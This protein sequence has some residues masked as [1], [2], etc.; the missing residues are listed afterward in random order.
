MTGTE[1]PRG[2]PVEFTAALRVAGDRMTVHKLITARDMAQGIGTP[3]CVVC[4][5]PV[6]RLS[7]IPVHHR[8]HRRHGGRGNPGNGITVHDA[9]HAWIHAHGRAATG[10]GWALY[11]SLRW[12]QAAGRAVRCARRGEIVLFD[13]PDQDGAWWRPASDAE[14]AWLDDPLDDPRAAVARG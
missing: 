5:Q 4:G 8:L 10:Q 2:W 7:D 14:V 9:C 6:G 3:C 11:G 1:P 12:Y 13:G